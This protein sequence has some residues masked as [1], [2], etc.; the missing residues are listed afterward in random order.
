MKAIILSAG[1][2]KRLLPLTENLPKCALPIAERTALEWQLHEI[3][4]CDIDDVVVVTGF[5]ADTVDEIVE[6]QTGQAVRTL[7]N[8]FFAHCDNLGTCWVARVEMDQPFVIINGDTIFEAGVLRKLLDNESEMQITLV[9]DSKD[10]Y[11]DDDMKVIADQGRLHRVG[12]HLDSALVTG[13]SI[14]MMSFRG[15]GPIEF[16]RKIAHLMRYGHGIKQWYLSAIDELAQA[17]FVGTCSIDGLSWCEIDDH[18]DLDHAATVI[19]SWYPATGS[20][21]SASG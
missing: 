15:N 13:E 12:K 4:Q 16:S 1:Q 8:P 9:T 20:V 14:G 19:G 6:R 3:S 5:G 11:D 21:A 2:G 10:N 7:Y 17:G 18:A